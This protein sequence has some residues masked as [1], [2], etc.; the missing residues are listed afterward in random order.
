[1]DFDRRGALRKLAGAVVAEAAVP[2]TRPGRNPP[3]PDAGTDAN[4][5]AGKGSEDG[6]ERFMRMAIERAKDNLAYPFGA[7]IVEIRTG[8]VLAGGV[9]VTKDNPLLHGEMAAMNDYVRR[10]GNR[11]WSDTTLYTTGEPCPMCMSAMIWANVQ[12]VVWGTSIDEIRRT[13]IAQSA[14]SA[15]EVAASAGSFYTPHLLLGGV[16]ADR[17]D[18]LFR[19]AQQRRQYAFPN[20]EAAGQRHE[21][22]TAGGGRRLPSGRG[23]VSANGSNGAGEAG[24]D[25]PRPDRTA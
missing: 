6:H 22:E 18:R 9:N 13:G 16:L 10:H 14:L 11:G 17:T 19:K 3:F 23:D 1:M 2:F 21:A 25:L 8:E 15:R 24:A 4:A 5:V 20:P 12:R 7:V